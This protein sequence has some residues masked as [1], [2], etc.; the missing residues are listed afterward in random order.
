MKIFILLFIFLLTIHITFQ[1]ETLMSHNEETNLEAT[2]EATEILEKIA[3]KVINIDKG[4]NNDGQEELIR[5]SNLF[6]GDIVLTPS[7]AENVVA[8]VVEKVESSGFDISDIVNE[9]HIRRKR[10]I[11]NTTYLKWDFPILYYVSQ[12]VDASKIEKALK[13]IENETCIRFKKTENKSQDKPGLFYFNDGDCYSSIGRLYDHKLQEISIAEN[14]DTIGTII[15]ETM[16]AL[17]SHHEQSRA[18]RN[19][20][21]TVLMSNVEE[22][23]ENNFFK[24]DF[25]DTIS[26]DVPYDYG[27]DMHYRTNAFSKNGEP[28]M[29]PTDPLYKKTIGV[30]AGLSF[31]DAKLLNKH[32]CMDKCTK[33]ITCY[34]G[35][36]VDPNNCL[37]CKCIS[38]FEGNDCSKMPDDSMECGDAVHE[39]EKNKTVRLYKRGK[40]DCIYHIKSKTN[41]TLKIIVNE[42][43]YYPGFK[44]TCNLDNSVEIKYYNDKSVTGALFCLSEKNKTI[45]AQGHH[46]IV[47][48]RSTQGTNF[49]FMQFENIEK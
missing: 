26:Y 9:T 10:T 28:T 27:S 30:D 21:L 12:K 44:S 22:G 42:I 47:H 49:L 41:S 37:K 15:H 36:Y 8:E 16:H 2:R 35:G 25:S 45:T 4:T 14:C 43:T 39:V 1:T 33:S 17:G 5:R 19:D 48:H 38:G 32:Y 29:L 6:E 13:N 18:D 23:F 20:Y 34:N 3:K 31:L 24:T 40:G 46:V 7:Q 11:D